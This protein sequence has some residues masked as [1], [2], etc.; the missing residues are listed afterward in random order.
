MA[1]ESSHGNTAS[2]QWIVRE[3]A[4]SDTMSVQRI[5]SLVAKSEASCAYSSERVFNN[6]VKMN[7]YCSSELDS[8]PRVD[9]GTCE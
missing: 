2:V 6:R 8:A 4:H 5:L 9:K 1:M 7:R 3:S